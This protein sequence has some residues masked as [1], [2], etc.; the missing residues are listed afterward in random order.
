MAMVPATTATMEQSERRN[1]RRRTSVMDQDIDTTVAQIQRVLERDYAHLDW[2]VLVSPPPRGAAAPAPELH[3]HART[4]DFRYRCRVSRPWLLI[5]AAPTLQL[6]VAE[7]AAEAE[8]RLART[9]PE[10]PAAERVREALR[11]A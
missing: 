8:Q 6:L 11:A 7:L 10:L 9:E 4:R 2:R 5:A 3:V 1:I